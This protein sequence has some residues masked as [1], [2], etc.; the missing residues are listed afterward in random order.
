MMHWIDFYALWI[1]RVWLML[2]AFVVTNVV[3]GFVAIEA[4]KFFLK[5]VEQ[6]GLFIKFVRQYYLK[7]N[8]QKEIDR[9]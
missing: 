2:V 4:M 9:E 5:R 1:G 8:T 3:I 6:Y 7:K